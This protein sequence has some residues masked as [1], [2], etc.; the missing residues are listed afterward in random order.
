M[1]QVPQENLDIN[2]WKTDSHYYCE[3]DNLDS[4]ED[5]TELYSMNQLNLK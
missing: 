4:A 1:N 3:N 5:N 2:E